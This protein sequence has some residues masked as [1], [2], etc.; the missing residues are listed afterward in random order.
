MSNAQIQV[1]D[2]FS[3]QAPSITNDIGGSRRILL[4]SD[5]SSQINFKG[6]EP[7]MS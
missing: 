5:N 6:I 1:V 4:Q 7:N 3:S 2:D